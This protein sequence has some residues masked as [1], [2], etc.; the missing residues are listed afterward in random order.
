MSK[1]S[2]RLSS[3]VCIQH[4]P[5]VPQQ[6]I[7]VKMRNS[8]FSFIRKGYYPTVEKIRFAWHTSVLASHNDCSTDISW[9]WSYTENLDERQN[10]KVRQLAEFSPKQPG[11][12]RHSSSPRCLTVWRCH[13]INPFISVLHAANGEGQYQQAYYHCSGVYVG[14]PFSRKGIN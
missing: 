2:S 9:L 8:R 12:H 13:L 4:P 10:A 7:E 6:D 3:Q 5:V 1:L 11:A 14:N